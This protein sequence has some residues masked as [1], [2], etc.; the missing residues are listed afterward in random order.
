MAKTNP[1][2]K[3]LAETRPGGLS[4]GV[5][6]EA[7]RP[8]F[9]TPAGLGEDVDSSMSALGAFV[10]PPR[11]KVIQGQAKKPFNEL[12]KPG[13]LCA[14]PMMRPIFRGFESRG[15][16]VAFHFVPVFFY[17]EWV[18]WNPYGTDLPPVIA[19]SFDPQSDIAMKSRNPGQRK[20]PCKERPTLPDGKPA[21][22]NHLEHLNFVIMILGDNEMAGLP[23]VLTFASG[24]HRAGTNFA[25]LIKQ[26]KSRYLHGLQFAARVGQR[27][28]K[29][30]SWYGIDVDNP[31]EDSGFT[32]YVMEQ[33]RFE[34]YGLIYEEFKAYHD[35]RRLEVDYDDITV[36][37]SVTR[38]AADPEM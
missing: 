11:I 21:F 32:P 31:A 34:G 19:R 28:N 3:E 26:R 15:A 8:D 1:T 13:D 30:G 4:S 2:S 22:I 17:P 23:I 35:E 36:E 37:G 10:R 24:E 18:S 9:L 27:E 12:F 25:S 33:V 29:T 16:N 5:G 6:I 14:V 38:P 20:E 7:Q